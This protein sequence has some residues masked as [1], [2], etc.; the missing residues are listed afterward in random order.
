MR[1]PKLLAIIIF[2][3]T[4]SFWFFLSKGN[5]FH[6]DEWW[7]FTLFSK[8]PWQFLFNHYGEHFIPLNFLHHYILFSLFGL[9]YI[10]FQ[11]SVSF[12]HAINTV[13]LFILIYQKTQRRFLAIIISLL[14]GLANVPIENLVWSLGVNYVLAGLMIFLAYYLFLRKKIFLSALLLIIS[15]LFHDITLLF[16][17]AFLILSLK[18]KKSWVTFALAL[19]FNLALVYFISGPSLTANVP[20][21]FFLFWK[22][23][24]FVF[25]GI[26]YGTILKF[27]V[28]HFYVAR[29]FLPFVRFFVVIVLVLGYFLRG[30]KIFSLRKSLVSPLYFAPFLICAYLA[31]APARLAFG[32]GASAISRYSYIPLFF[33]ALFIAEIWPRQ[34]FIPR[35]LT[36]F[37]LFIFL[38]IQ[39][40][41]SINFS[42]SYWKPMVDRDRQFITDIKTLFDNSE[43]VANYPVPGISEKIS[44]SDFSYLLPKN[45]ALKFVTPTTNETKNPITQEIYKK[46]INEYSR[47]FD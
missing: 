26:I 47:K 22:I 11:I 34:N 15:P 12:F 44:L 35:W 4:F 6:W 23:P 21:D 25:Q 16:P 32:P 1:N 43:R 33:L 8:S 27:L 24:L 45:S 7:F 31:A 46:I 9:N 41:A 37:I 17:L 18:H 42:Y 30:R 36:L 3:L 28:P 39:I 5:Y 14:F 20:K 40:L 2:L 38:P 19:I 29:P 10:P 13:L